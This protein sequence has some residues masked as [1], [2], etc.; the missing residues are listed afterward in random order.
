M[1]KQYSKIRLIG[2]MLTFL[3][4]FATIVAAWAVSGEDIEDNITAIAEL[5]TKGCGPAIQNKFDIALVQKD[6][7]IIQESQTAMEIE[8]KA[9]RIEQQAGF[10]E[11]LERLPE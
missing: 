10:K 5:E 7:E 6:I 1:A 4:I 9:I 3:A 11:I 2:L 8:Q